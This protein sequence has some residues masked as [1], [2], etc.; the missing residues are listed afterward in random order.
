MDNVVYQ[1][2]LGSLRDKS[3]RVSKLAEA[4]SPLIGADL[5]IVSRAAALGRTDLL[6]DM[7]GEFPELQGRMGYYYAL[8][9]GEP[10]AVAAAIEEQYL[11]RQA[12]DRLPTTPAGQA[13]SIADRLDTL[14][15]IFCLGKRPTGNKDPFSLRRQALGL[16]RILIE[17]E[18][19]ADLPKFLATAVALQPSQQD[20]TDVAHE[21]Y[22]FIVGRM[23][24]WYLDGQA[25]DFAS[26][27]ITGEMF[28]AVRKRE[29]ASPLDFHQRLAAVQSFMGLDSAVSLAAANKRIANILKKAD[30]NDAQQIDESLFDIQ[31]EKLLYAA[32]VTLKPEH[33]ADLANRNYSAVLQRLADLRAPVD[34]YFEQ[35]MVMDEDEKKR[36]NRL[37]QLGQLRNLFLD[38][39]DLSCIQA[40]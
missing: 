8:H 33:Q 36:S 11:P 12:G 14:A 10:E 3:L 2:G 40:P 4:L 23:R 9:D 21:L 18:I 16:V 39:A 22:E 6:T 20:D 19:D 29:P 32:V 37:A 13:L 27:D 34:G 35:V 30:T 7:V 25:S 28:E 38:V 31:E 5:N 15:G 26:G 17:G 24:A 1:K